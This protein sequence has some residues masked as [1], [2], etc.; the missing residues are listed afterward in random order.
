[1]TSRRT[2]LRAGLA[3][4]P[5]SFLWRRRTAAAAERSALVRDPDSL[6]DLP[7]GFSY[8]IVD[9]TGETMSDGVL[10]PR[11][12][13]GMA[14]F[15]GPG[16]TLI[17]M[18]NH[19][20]GDGGGGVSRVVLDAG[21]LERI[22]SNLVL[23]GTSRNCG[24]GV[25]P[26]GWLSCEEDTSGG[27][28]HVYLCPIDAETLA[29]AQRIAGYGRFNHE[30]AVVDPATRVA[31]LTEDRPDSCLYRF[32]PAAPRLPFVGRLQALRVDGEDRSDT[33]TSRRVGDAWEI[34]WV[35]VTE[36]DPVEDTCRDEAAAAGAATFVRG[37]GIWLHDGA[38]YF[39]ATSGGPIGKGQVFRLDPEG[40]GGRLHLLAQSEDAAI[41]DKPDGIAVAPW[42]DVFLCED[43]TGGDSL[44]ILGADGGISTFA[45]KAS[46]DGELAG[47]CFSPDGETMFVN[48]QAEGLTLAIS[49]SF[50][51][52]DLEPVYADDRGGCSAS[53]GAGVGTAVAVSLAVRA[54]L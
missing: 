37:E 53:D 12:P 38:V 24:G 46:G 10:V 25:S 45:R 36:P 31:Y 44:R 27:H 5:L 1:L 6:L 35:D 15:R 48:L 52:L 32:V 2:I 39:T 40:D 28:G 3:A 33:G 19:E 30:G 43:G 34:G 16:S 51:G 14:C 49:G 47:I 7:P 18:R 21:T 11:A 4:L 50:D 20:I 13:D 42:G 41:L 23:H 9:R 17:L 29:P 54:A 8:R 26:W 22:S